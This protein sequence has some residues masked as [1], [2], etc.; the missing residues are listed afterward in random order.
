MVR[1]EKKE[2]SAIARPLF[3]VEDKV[4]FQDVDAAGIMF[5][6][7]FFDRVHDCYEVWLAHVGTPLP[8]V[9]A[10]RSWAAPLRHAECDY[11]APARHGDVLRVQLVRA[12][13]EVS[14]LSLGWVVRGERETSHAKDSVDP[15]TD[16]QVSGKVLAVLQTAHA[17]VDPGS[18]RRLSVPE[19]I[20][21]WLA[22]PP[23]QQGGR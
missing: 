1:F 10:D 6:A 3:E 23:A 5:F 2:L 22:Q 11:V 14:E 16:A 18:W 8:R 17:F 9:L 12:E 15:E 13:V 19:Q 21:S 20:A 7:R 4:R